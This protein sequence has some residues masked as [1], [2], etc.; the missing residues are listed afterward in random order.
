MKS[1]IA[2]AALAALAVV[3]PARPA[4]HAGKA[5]FDQS[6]KNCHGAEG[7]GDRMA[8]KYYQMTIPRLT[9]SYVQNKS[10]EELRQI[11]TKGTR[12]MEPARM[13]Q[14]KASHRLKLTDA[15][16]DQAIAYVRALK[17]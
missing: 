4:E 15:Q 11:I 12:K 13:G 5:V 2:V 3:L 1:L 6:C 16:V 17:K 8:D 14:P 9:S 7:K 10:D